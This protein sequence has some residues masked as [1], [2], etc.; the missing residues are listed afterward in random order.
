MKANFKISNVKKEK[1]EVENSE[2]NKQVS[3]SEFEDFIIKSGA[4]GSF[5]VYRSN[6]KDDELGLEQL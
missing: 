3:S 6:K 2:K 4:K 5:M 1:P